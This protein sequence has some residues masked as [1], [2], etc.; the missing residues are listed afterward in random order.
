MTVEE[1]RVRTDTTRKVTWIV[2]DKDPIT[3]SR[4]AKFFP[5]VV[6]TDYER[7]GANTPWRRPFKVLIRGVWVGKKNQPLKTETR[8]WYA[9][10]GTHD[11][12]A[13]A[14]VLDLIDGFDPD[15]EPD[16]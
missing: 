14:W 2:T 9:T 6:V 4:G 5:R 12:V 13:T 15:K 8:D 3:H 10:E 7:R 1:R 16:T 11:A